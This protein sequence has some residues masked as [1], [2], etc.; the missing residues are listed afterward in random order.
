MKSRTN[1][2]DAWATDPRFLKYLTSI[3]GEMNDP[4]PYSEG[5]PEIDGLATRWKELNYVN[6]PFSSFLK[7]S[8]VQRAI[9]N[10]QS[11]GNT[12]I[13]LLPASVNSVLFHEVI[14]PCLHPFP[15]RLPTC[16]RED[17]MPHFWEVTK[18]L[19][20][21]SKRVPFMGKSYDSAGRLTA[22]NN[23]HLW[24]YSDRKPEDK[25]N[26]PCW[27]NGAYRA[28]KHKKQGGQMDLML[29]CV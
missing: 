22:Y 8:F 18:G 15:A 4:C 23:W 16:Q 3:F 29:A 5:E 2:T 12:S 11:Y 14:R 24:E 9:V 19:A 28:P 7:N 27:S 17:G 26:K 25:G 1:K 10:R 6:P 13:L 20:F 21:L